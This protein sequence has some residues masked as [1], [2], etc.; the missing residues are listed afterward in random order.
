MVPGSQLVGAVAEVGGHVKGPLIVGG[1]VL[2]GG[3]VLT[4]GEGGGEGT[5]LQEVGQVAGQSYHEGGVV[6]SGNGQLSG[7][8]VASHNLVGVDH[9]VDHI[10]V[11]RGGLGGHQALP[12][13]HEV[14]GSN[15]LAVGP[16][17]VGANLEGVGDG[18]VIVDH[19]LVAL[20]LT[21]GQL[22]VGAG[23]VGTGSLNLGVLPLH[24]AL[25]HV[26]QHD[27]AVNGGVQSGVNGLG[28]GSDVQGDFKG[29]AGAGSGSALRRG[30]AA[31]LRIGVGRG[32]RRGGARIAAASQQRD[33]KHQRQKQRQSLLHWD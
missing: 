33:H 24:Q 3:H 25:E 14:T 2:L 12:G 31:G 30:G 13:V 6:G 20:G 9:T 16:A 29:A 32:R 8:H 21:L 10:V 4:D 17:G 23:A 28:L 7:V 27:G 26:A 22:G 19:L 18:A 1:A 5:D 11:I 15:G